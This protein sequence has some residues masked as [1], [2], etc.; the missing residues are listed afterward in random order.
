MRK[1]KFREEGNSYICRSYRVNTGRGGLFDPPPFL[2]GLNLGKKFILKQSRKNCGLLIYV[3]ASD[4]LKHR[5]ELKLVHYKLCHMCYV[6]LAVIEN[7]FY[8]LLISTSALQTFRLNV[9]ALQ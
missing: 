1:L 2:I 8:V 6:P 7:W 5:D 3:T 9:S 4:E